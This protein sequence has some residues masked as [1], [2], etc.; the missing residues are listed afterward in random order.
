MKPLCGALAI[1]GF[2]FAA[3]ACSTTRRK[4]HADVGRAME[5]WKAAQSVREEMRKQITP[6]EDVQRRLGAPGVLGTNESIWLQSGKGRLIQLPARVRRV[7]LS[8]PELASIVVLGP[9]TI[10]INAKELPKPAMDVGMMA[11]SAGSRIGIATGRTLT[12]EPHTAETTLAIWYGG[13]EAPDVHSVLVAD[14]ANVQVMLEVT[15]AQLDRTAM[16][17]E[18]VDF[19]QV[20]SSFVSAYF[21]GGGFGPRVPGLAT[22]VPPVSTPLLPLTATENKPQFAFQLPQEDITAFVSVL[23]TEGLATIL[24]RPKL[25]AMSGQTAV[26]QVGGEIPIRIVTSFVSD[27]QFKPFGA[28]VTF[29][30]RVS[31][32]GDIMLTVTPEVSQPDFSTEVEGIPTFRTRRASTSARLK[33]G[34]TLVIGGLME[35]D[36]REQ[37]SGLPYLKD[38][39]VLGYLFRTTTY[40][41]TITEVMVVV[42]PHIIDP[43]QPGTKVALPTDRPPLTKEDVRTEP[44]AAEVTR[45]RVPEVLLP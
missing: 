33:N 6:P 14:F 29:L 20:G 2:V 38:I 25:V 7:S 23:Q 22:T 35:R 37:V 12:A 26:L 39:P 21:M 40:A 34:E 43:M 4:P 19:R 3:G 41:E 15:V 9:R 28:L 32:D 18:G 36:R 30:P 10:M 16:E 11:P 17:Q 13:A 44:E 8:N 27:I 45:P 42:T 1:L 24:A 31:D 5:Q